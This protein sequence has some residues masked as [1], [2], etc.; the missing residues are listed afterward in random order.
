MRLNDNVRFLFLYGTK[1]VLYVQIVHCHNAEVV[2]VI[3]SFS[4]R[5]MLFHD[6]AYLN[7]GQEVVDEGACLAIGAQHLVS[8]RA[9]LIG[10]LHLDK[11]LVC[12]HQLPVV[13]FDFFLLDGD[14]AVDAPFLVLI[15][16]RHGAHERL[17][18]KAL[19]LDRIRLHLDSVAVLEDVPHPVYG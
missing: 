5:L 6:L 2:F 1:Q 8:E 15:V 14:L 19:H 16:T 3:A 18:H 13:F 7:H 17:F 11:R 12:V 10:A 9:I 4:H